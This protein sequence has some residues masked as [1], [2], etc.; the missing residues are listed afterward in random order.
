M[1]TAQTEGRVGRVE[2]T[3]SRHE[4][5]LV[6][7]RG[8][9]LMIPTLGLYRFWLA[10]WKRRFYWQNT[11][12]DGDPLEYSGTASQLLLGFLFSV[13]FFLPIYVALLYVAMQDPRLTLYGYFGTAGILWFLAGYAIYR[14]RDF[15]LSR[16]LWRGIRFDQKGNG[17]AYAVRRFVWS[18]LMVATIGL[19]Y[20]WMAS[21]LW[22]YR[23]RN[24]WY[25]DR[26]FDIAGNWRAFALP[27][28][29]TYLVNVVALVATVT[30]IENAKS[31]IQIGDLSVPE[32][33]QLLACA[34]CLALFALSLAWYRATTATRMLSTVTL[35][36]ARLDVKVPPASLFGQYAAY[37]ASLVVLIAFLALALIVAVAAL[38]A[39]AA[40]NGRTAETGLLDLL[41]HG[42][43]NVA[44]L[45]ALY[46]VIVGAL[47]LLSELVLGLGWWRLLARGATIEKPDSLRT[48]NATVED[49]TLAGQG[50]ADALNVGAY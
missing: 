26:R 3:G 34:A 22:H 24:C 7:L 44:L 40:Q 8:Y 27:Y 43:L 33:A 11:V 39:M 12:I 31:F 2:F 6:I 30:W 10:T 14:A 17:W 21:S 23:W 36:E 15:R 41:Q 19:I 25:G 4:L 49:R 1:S 37:V 18:I 38:Y 32:P 16:T 5:M 42:T 29:V 48:V 46:L 28:Y 50:L 45:I 47:G 20:P 9:S 35:G 13:A